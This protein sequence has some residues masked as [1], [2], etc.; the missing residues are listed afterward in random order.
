MESLQSMGEKK[1]KIP[2]ETLGIPKDSLGIPKES[3]EIPGE[4]LR[5]PQGFQEGNDRDIGALA[6]DS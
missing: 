6:R 3:L 2:K 5:D 4:S 1:R